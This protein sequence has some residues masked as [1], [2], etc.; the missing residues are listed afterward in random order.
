MKRF[1]MLLVCL[2]LV[3]SGT[4]CCWWH[5][6]CCGGGGYGGGYGAGYSPC[7]PCGA[8][9]CGTGYGAGYGPAYNYGTPTTYYGGATF[10]ASPYGATVTAG[11]PV[12]AVPQ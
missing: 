9:G 8:G 4:G 5:N 6:P 2:A 1:A 3:V 12:Q 7:G 11:V 10:A